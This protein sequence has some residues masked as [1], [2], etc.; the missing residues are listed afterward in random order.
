MDISKKIEEAL[1]DYYTD[2]YREKLG[3]TDWESRVDP[4]FARGRNLWRTYSP[5]G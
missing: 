4:A 5:E 3:L 2:I 1:R